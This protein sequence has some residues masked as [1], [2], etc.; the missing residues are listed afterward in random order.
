MRSRGFEIAYRT[1][2][3]GPTL[4]LL[5]GWSMKADQWWESGYV[6]ALRDEFR[7]IAVDRL[8]HGRSDKPHV[9]SA[10]EESLIRRPRAVLDAEGS[11]GARVG[12]FDGSPSRPN[13]AVTAAGAEK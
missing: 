6:D 12:F 11:P 1:E 3:R 13:P 8:G 7:V 10:Y 4:L 9:A 2:G 5:S